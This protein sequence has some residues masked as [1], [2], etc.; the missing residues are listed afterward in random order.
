[1]LD[2][3]DPEQA[4][5]DWIYSLPCRVI[6][7]PALRANFEKTGPA[8]AVSDDV[9]SCIRIHCC[10][11]SHRAAME[12]R[13]SLPVFPRETAWQS[14]YTTNISKKGC[15][16]FHSELLYP[17]ERF[18]LIMLKGIQ[19]VIEVAWCRRLESNCFAVGSRFLANSPAPANSGAG[20]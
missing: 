14:V 19:Q 16:F 18:T 10:G 15:G 4:I 20:R 13:Q 5:A 2:R 8:P 3:H 7:P 6:F 17:G 11:K 9:R 12:L 1:M